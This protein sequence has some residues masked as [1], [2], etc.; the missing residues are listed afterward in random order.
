MNSIPGRATHEI[1]AALEQIDAPWVAAALSRRFPGLRVK[2][3]ETLGVIRGASTKVRIRVKTDH[4][5]VPESLI[6]KGGFEPHSHLMRG[7]Q[8]NEMHAYRSLVPTLDVQAPACLFAGQAPDGRAVVIL[9]DLT[10]KQ[11]VFLSLLDPLDFDSAARFLAP[12]ARI[13]ARWWN[14]PELESGGAFEWAPKPA[15]GR[16]RDYIERL[17][18]PEVFEV[19]R[20][21]PRG[22]ATPRVLAQPERIRRGLAEMRRLQLGTPHTMCHGDTHLGNLY[23]TRDGAPGFLDWSPR[24][25][26]WQHEFSYFLV[27]ALDVP[28][29]RRWEAALLEFYLLQLR[30]HHVEAP[31]FE[32]AW[33]AYRRDVMWGFFVFLL[34]DFNFQPESVNTA[35][36][37]RFAAAMLDHDTF[38]LLG[39]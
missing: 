9:E 17:T 4:A 10:Q 5:A 15:E 26:P 36:A 21:A 8:L 30:S 1:P 22:A 27:A 23:W 25:A 3:M 14:S 19:Y 39:V 32:Q 18:A 13:H 6:V 12:L 38:G 11:P 7:M 24:N 31:T 20:A 28:D 2:E 33:L 37:S 16:Y 29:R 35:A 34:N